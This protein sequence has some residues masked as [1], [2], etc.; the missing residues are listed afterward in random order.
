M[1]IKRC[2]YCKAIVDDSSEYC[3]NCGTK[4]LFP[5]DEIKG[6]NIPGEKIV[7]DVPDPDETELP[8]AD[9]TEFG[10][11]YQHPEDSPDLEPTD[12]EEADQSLF[13]DELSASDEDSGILDMEVQKLKNIA[14]DGSSWLEVELPSGEEKEKLD[15]SMVPLDILTGKAEDDEKKSDTD[16]GGIEDSVYH[17][18]IRD[19]EDGPFKRGVTSSKPLPEM[20]PDTTD[21]EKE[22]EEYLPLEEQEDGEAEADEIPDPE[23]LENPEEPDK[24]PDDEAPEEYLAGDQ[25]S[26][27]DPVEKEKDD[28][29]R[30]LQSLR[31]ERR[32]RKPEIPETGTDLPPWAKQIQEEEQADAGLKGESFLPQ[33]KIEDGFK[34]VEEDVNIPIPDIVGPEKEPESP[35]DVDTSTG[36]EWDAAELEPLTEEAQADGM[37]FDME[38]PPVMEEDDFSVEDEVEE[39]KTAA[40]DKR[41]R[42]FEME[43]SSGGGWLSRW[44]KGRIVDVLLV[45]S[46][47]FLALILA[48]FVLKKTVLQLIGPSAPTVL[49]FFGVLVI[50]Y[51]F[52]FYFFL[53]STLGDRLFPRKD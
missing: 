43:T 29:E 49:L 47:W 1:S 17:M 21:F 50:V 4:L 3:A 37:L 33:E 12:S 25:M 52:L 30:F 20:P 44:I 10:E 31:K 15:E 5:E 2:P 41:E 22:R 35:V 27:F 45:G 6:E 9:D 48:S 19:A 8:V 40:V 51:F 34:D 23:E 26:I 16:E 7:D 53:G 38:T 13:E 18:R 24:S 36:L 32:G 39:V 28:I 42:L 11:V 14:D 46:V